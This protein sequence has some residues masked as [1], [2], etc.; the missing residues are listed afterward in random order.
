MNKFFQKEKEEEE[1]TIYKDITILN[2]IQSDLTKLIIEQ[3]EKLDKIENNMNN[4]ENKITDSNNNLKDARY[5][6]LGYKPLIIGGVIGLVSGGV[7]LP[8]GIISN[9][10]GLF[11]GS[12]CGYHYKKI[13]Y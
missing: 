2:E 3:G 11:L 4:T 6:S 13:Y 7:L 9:V 10:S 8:Y 1:A 5:Y 12:Y